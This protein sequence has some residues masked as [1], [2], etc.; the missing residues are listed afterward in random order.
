VF[1][2]KKLMDPNVPPPTPSCGSSQTQDC[3]SAFT[4]SSVF[5]FDG[6]GKAEVVYAD[7]QYMRIYDGTTGDVL[8][9]CATPPAPCTS[10]RWSPT[11]TTTA[12]WSK[13]ATVARI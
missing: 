3:S 12:R 9:R 11:S 13:I 6:N 8:L 5:D 7:E 4:G 10:T 2:G 1:S